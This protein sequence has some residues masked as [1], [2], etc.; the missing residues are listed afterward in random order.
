MYFTVSLPLLDRKNHK[1]GIVN[2]KFSAILQKGKI[3][4]R[5]ILVAAE[6]YLG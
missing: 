2:L 6:F 4:S 1:S 5:T 3:L